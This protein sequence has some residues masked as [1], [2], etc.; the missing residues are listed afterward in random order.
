MKNLCPV[1]PFHG[2]TKAR[3]DTLFLREYVRPRFN[4]HTTIFVRPFVSAL[5]TFSLSLLRDCDFVCNKTEKQR[6]SLEQLYK[7]LIPKKYKDNK[8]YFISIQNLYGRVIEK[9]KNL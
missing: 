3:H 7:W 9:G 8:Y 1:A 6:I 4:L 2:L 5:S